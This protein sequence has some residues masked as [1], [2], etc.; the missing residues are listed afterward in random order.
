MPDTMTDEQILG[1]PDS[2][3]SE[4]PSDV[5]ESPA[6]VETQTEDVSAEENLSPEQLKPGT[7]EQPKPQAQPSKAAPTS[8]QQQETIAAKAAELDRADAA[9]ANGDVEGMA[10]TFEQL[11]GQNPAGLT[12][13]MWMASRFLEQRAPEQYSQF[14][15]MILSD[16]LGQLGVTWESLVKIGEYLRQANDRESFNELN[17]IATLFQQVGHGPSTPESQGASMA[18]YNSQIGAMLN[19]SVPALIRST[20]GERFSSVKPV[21]Q[22][23]L[24]QAAN[25][26]VHDLLLKDQ[27]LKAALQGLS[28]RYSDK[29]GMRIYL[30]ILA[31]KLRSIVPLVSKKLANEYSELFKN[32]PVTPPTPKPAQ[33]A[34]PAIVAPRNMAEARARNMTMADVLKATEGE[35]SNGSFLT[36]EDADSMSDMDVLNS[37]RIPQARKPWRPTDELDAL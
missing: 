15:K 9:F 14:S 7:A 1:L 25:L 5:S 36:Q 23:E 3:E 30:E 34:K 16:Q 10:E 13:A 24:L 11:F 20:F 26:A 18:S 19:R 33:A 29:E 31:P 28:K 8:E 37:Q 35:I 27:K 12:D 2:V 4:T 21:D 6:P 32:I 17:K 22:K